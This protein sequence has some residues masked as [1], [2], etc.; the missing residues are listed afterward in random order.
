MTCGNGF[1]RYCGSETATLSPSGSKANWR[2]RSVDRHLVR[3]KAGIPKEYL[4]QELGC[5]SGMTGWRRL[6]DWQQAGVWERL[7]HILL[8]ELHDAGELDDHRATIDSSKSRAISGGESTEPIPTDR[9]KSGGKHY[10]LVDSQGRPVGWG[11][12]A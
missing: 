10:I 9:C 5:G 6:R 1:N 2:L 8:E 3:F 4:P 7:H 12:S 11:K